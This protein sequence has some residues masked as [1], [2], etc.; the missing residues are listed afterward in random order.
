MK[1]NPKTTE[2]AS[3]LIITLFVIFLITTAIAIAVNMTTTTVRQTG[4]SRDFS[5]LRSAAEG[6]VDYAYGVWL[7][8]VNTSY[9]NVG[10]AVLAGGI[11]SAPALP[12]GIWY[13]LPLQLTGTDPYGKPYAANSK[14]PPAPTRVNLDKYPGWLGA[15]TSY[16]AAAKVSAKTNGNRTIE[17]GVKRAMNYTSVPLFQATAFF[18]DDL[19]LYRTAPMT[20]GGLVHTNSTAYV[21]SQSATTPSLTFTGNLSHVGAYIDGKYNYKDPV[22]G[23]TTQRDAPPQA[24]NWSGYAANN[25]FPPSYPSGGID[26]QVNT[27]ERM[28]PLGT[29]PAK[30]IFPPTFDSGG[31]PKTSGDVNPNDDGM[32]ELIEPP[33]T[34]V[35]PITQKITT[36]GNYDDPQAVADRRLY[37]KAGIRIRVTGSTYSVTTANGTSL[38]SSQ[39]TALKAALSQT[40]IYDRREA[41][42][43]DITSL[44]IAKAKTKISSSVPG[45]LEDPTFNR[46]IYIDDT[47]STGY[48]DPKAVRLLNGSNLPSGG[49]T[50]VTQ[51][52]LYIQ[53]NYNTTSQ[54]TRGSAAVFADAVTILSNGWLDA[55]SSLAIS[56]RI[57]LETTVNTAIVAGFLPSGWTNPK[58]GARYEYSGGLNNFPR[59]L[60]DWSLRKLNYTGSMIELFTSQVATGPWDTGTTYVP[61]NR[62]WDFDS[63]FIENPPPGGLDSVYIGR[64]ALTRF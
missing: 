46:I 37:N 4:S 50:V 20:I 18:E 11:G 6:T 14:N 21:S 7:E 39:I 56:K 59:F 62:I 30:V 38:T 47:S 28:E 9:G 17:Y 64:G 61:P 42:T 36:T 3:A 54:D 40:N 60:E 57:A 52:P 43:V 33:N 45:P 13:S 19:E 29:D 63:N 8:K 15:N 44:D 34:Y 23:V 27:V 51:N 22:T 48:T 16:L 2:R 32:R 5:A 58:T 49:L 31:I 12:S 24:W 35:N 53:G 25:S 10:S 26:Q 1:P 41:K 55:A